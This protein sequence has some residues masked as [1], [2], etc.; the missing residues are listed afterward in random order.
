MFPT[1]RPVA[2]PP[3]HAALVAAWALATP[4]ALEADERDHGHLHIEEEIV[5]YG[6]AQRHIGTAASA[7]EGVVGYADYHLSPLLRVGELVEAVPGMVAT[8]HSGTGKANQYFLRGFNLDHGTDFSAHLDDVP[9]NMRTHGHG[10]GYLDLNFI[11]PE[12]VETAVYRKG[13]YHAEKGDF[14]SA[15]SVDFAYRT[16]LPEPLLQVALGE[17]GYT[18]GM[19][20]GSAPLP[21]GVLTGAVDATRYDG[22]WR[23]DENLEQY[24]FHLGYRQGFGAVEVRAA[25]HGYDG[26]WTATDQIPRRAVRAGHLDRTGFVDPHLGGETRRI[27]GTAQV[28]AGSWRV[29]AY[30]LDYDFTLFSN[31]TYLLDDPL[32]G[33]EFE[34]RDDRTVRGLWLHGETSTWIADLPVS[35]RW[36]ADARFDDIEEVGLYGTAARVRTDV[37]RRDRVEEASVGGYGELELRLVER[38]RTVLGLR[39]DYYDWDVSA[40]RPRDDTAGDDRLASPKVSVAYEVADGLEAYLSWGRGFHSNDVRVLRAAHGPARP[41]KAGAPDVL[42]ASEG[43]EIGLRFEPDPS[44]NATLIGFWLELD[45]ELVY[46]GDAGVTEPS[47]ASSRKG[48]EL[49]SFW[50]ARDWLT[51]NAAYTVSDAELDGGEEIPGAVERTFHAGATALLGG[52]VHASLNARHLGEAPLVEDGSVRSDASWLVHAGVAWHYRRAEFALD[53]FNVLDSRDDDIAYYYASRLP[54]EPADGVL[55]THFHPLEPRTIRARFVLHF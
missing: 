28:D 48:L 21:N 39:A 35:I 51:L 43:G 45:S 30:W 29:G 34:Q 32:R 20:A 41:S 13:V 15:G 8:Q 24:K 18:R 33:D 14:S 11:I 46:V 36:G 23:L 17:H 55:D 9:V 38:L 54:G 47:A 31:F 52:G 49:T 44:F 42:A 5:V 50:Q 25:L 2:P 53:L 27:A 22:P 7:S 40:M 12:L 37:R 4:V 6:R 19:S 26:Q 3:V 1:A 16:E 10:Q